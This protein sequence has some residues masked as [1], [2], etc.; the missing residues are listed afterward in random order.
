MKNFSLGFCLFLGS[1][2]LMAACGDSGSGGNGCPTG[3]VPCDGVCIDEIAPNLTAIQDQIFDT[4][5]TA[6]VCHDSE[7]PAGD[8]D[9][10][11]LS[12]SEQNLIDV[13]SS[14]VP[15]S[16]RVASGDSSASYLMNKLLGEGMAPTTQQ[17]PIGGVLC[18]ARIDAVEQWIDAGAPIQ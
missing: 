2:A 12:A 5:C 3:Q 16:L 10:S 14:Q 6:S 18:D 4:T 13:S 15:S 11:T 7:F 17:M 9:M 1:I 8:L